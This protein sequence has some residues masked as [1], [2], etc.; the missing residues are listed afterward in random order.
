MVSHIIC[1]KKK[2]MQALVMQFGKD[3]GTSFPFL[4]TN[5][6]DYSLLRAVVDSL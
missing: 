6:G 2:I 5:F 1:R 4:C 3:V